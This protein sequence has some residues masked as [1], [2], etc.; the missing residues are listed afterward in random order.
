MRPES[1]FSSRTQI[2]RP[3]FEWGQASKSYVW[4][5]DRWSQRKHCG[6]HRERLPGANDSSRTR[7][8]AELDAE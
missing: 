2:L 6:A 4:M 5:V 1:L 8:C 7:K 3:Y